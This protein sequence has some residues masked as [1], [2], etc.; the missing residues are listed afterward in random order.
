MSGIRWTRPFTPGKSVVLFLV[1]ALGFGLCVHTARLTLDDPLARRIWTA[2]LIFYFV[3][4][5][6]LVSITYW[7]FDTYRLLK[8]TVPATKQRREV[9]AEPEEEGLPTFHILIASYKASESLRP[10]LRAVANLDYPKDNCHA[11]VITNHN[12]LLES[13]AQ[14]GSLIREVAGLGSPAPGDPLLSSIAWRCESE[15]LASLDAWVSQVEGGKLQP[16]LRCREIAPTILHDLL[17]RL[18]RTADRHAFYASGTLDPLG[19]PTNDIA[20]IERALRR[21]ETK[22]SEVAADFERLLGSDAVYRR[23]DIE[24]QLI[25]NA[26]QSSVLS[27]IGHALCDRLGKP[28]LAVSPLTEDRLAATV[29]RMIR[30]TQEVVRDVIEE[31]ATSQVHLLDSDGRGFKPGALN[32]A[33]RH[34]RDSGLLSEPSKTYFIIID[35]DSLMPKHALRTIIREL[36][37]ADPPPPIMQM[38]SIPTANFFSGGWFSQFIAFADAVGAVGKWA[39]T[40]RQRLRPDLHAGSRVVIPASLTAYIA[41]HMGDPWAETTLT[42]D[43]RIIVGQFGTMDGARNKTLM[44][45]AYLLEAVPASTD[46]L[47]TYISFWNQRRRWTTGGYD[48]LFYMLSPPDWLRHAGFDRR[49]RCWKLRSPGTVERILMGVRQANRL[50]LW[51]WD[52][53]WWGLGGVLILTHWWLVSLAI[54]SP[55][56]TM[57]WLGLC[58][59]LLGPLFFLIAPGRQLNTFVAGGISPRKMAQLYVT[60]F[61]AIWLYCLPVAATQ[62]ACIFGFRSKMLDWK[63]T[64]KP[65]YHLDAVI[66]EEKS[67]H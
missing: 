63:P 11:W 19:L 61:V 57:S 29:S 16:Y 54:V 65:R 17:F 27:R 55:S 38:A 43:A 24:L 26:A 40:T 59:L 48:E 8:T 35:S 23:K 53:L 12:E 45:P 5:Q 25:G 36:R 18:L 28:D 56:A 6:R 64:Q 42:E 30:S 20:A 13:E 52:H 15:R 31:S 46:F 2:I 21:I 41:E 47:N 10:V 67:R 50:A 34:I 1:L 3:F 7:S 39:R 49:E 32:F 58:V 14:V 66:P 9:E 4:Y 44:A 33:F 37:A 51:I 22:S 62:I 60:S